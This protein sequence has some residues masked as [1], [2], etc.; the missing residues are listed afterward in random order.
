MFDS[1]HLPERYA[2]N[3]N[4]HL[5]WSSDD[6]LLVS[7]VGCYVAINGKEVTKW[8]N[9]GDTEAKAQLV[10]ERE[11]AGY[12]DKVFGL[13]APIA[14]PIELLPIP[15]AKDDEAKVFSRR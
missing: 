6:E 13:S 12:L 7:K 1:L 9:C 2:D 8:W 4:C 15:E 11:V 10:I 5:L 14:P 3:E